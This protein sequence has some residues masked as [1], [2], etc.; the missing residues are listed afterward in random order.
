MARIQGGGTVEPLTDAERRDMR[1]TLLHLGVQS[2]VVGP[3]PK[4]RAEMIGTYRDLLGS[5]HI[6]TGGVE[7]WPNASVAARRGAGTCT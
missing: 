4:G 5:D 6:S 1:C 2:V 7:L 3:M